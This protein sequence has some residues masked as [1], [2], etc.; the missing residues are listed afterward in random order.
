MSVRAHFADILTKSLKCFQG[1]GKAEVGK[2][3]HRTLLLMNEQKVDEK[4]D[5]LQEMFASGELQAY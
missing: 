4:Q 5:G 1:R 3:R 2:T